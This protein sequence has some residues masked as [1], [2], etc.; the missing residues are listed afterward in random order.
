VRQVAALPTWAS[1]KHKRIVA[2]PAATNR[3]AA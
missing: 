1:G 3:A 2:L